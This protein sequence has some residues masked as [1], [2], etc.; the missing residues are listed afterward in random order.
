MKP[1]S[2]Y[3]A[4]EL[5][6]ERLFIR[7]VRFPDDPPIQKFWENWMEQHPAMYDTV[8]SARE[9]VSIASDWEMDTLANSEANTLWGRIRST[10]ETLPDIENLDPSVKSL[11]ANWYFLRWSAGIGAT[12]LLI[13]LWI[14]WEPQ[15]YSGHSHKAVIAKTDSTQSSRSQDSTRH[16]GPLKIK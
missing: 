13:M 8:H 14:F 1:Y 5:A 7:W 9:L 4:E 16:N 10:I 11:A 3:T 6:M 12:V 2:E 15:V